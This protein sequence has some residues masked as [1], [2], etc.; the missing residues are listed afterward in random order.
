[1]PLSMVK[2]PSQGSLDGD[3]N[4]P[5]PHG[6]SSTAGGS[7]LGGMGRTLK[8][9]PYLSEMTKGADSDLMAMLS[10]PGG[11]A[12]QA[13]GGRAV[14]AGAP[15][16]GGAAGID[17]LQLKRPGAA[18][19]DVRQAA[20]VMP[21]ATRASATH[22]AGRPLQS[23]LRSNHQLRAAENSQANL[24]S[25]EMRKNTSVTFSQSTK[26]GSRL[27]LVNAQQSVAVTSNKAN[28]TVA[29][30]PVRRDR[31]VSISEEPSSA[32]RQ[33]EQQQGGK[34]QFPFYFDTLKESHVVSPSPSPLTQDFVSEQP[35]SSLQQQESHQDRVKTKAKSVNTLQYYYKAG[36]KSGVSAQNV[37]G[38][39]EKR[40]FSKSLRN[41]TF[42]EMLDE[43]DGKEGDLNLRLRNEQWK[44][45]RTS[46][47]GTGDDDD[48][49]KEDSLMFTPEHRTGS[50]LGS[51]RVLTPSSS[52]NSNDYM[53]DAPNNRSENTEGYS[54]VPMM[55]MHSHAQSTGITQPQ[56]NLI[57]SH[58]GC[59]SAYDLAVFRRAA[60]RMKISPQ[61]PSPSGVH[62]IEPSQSSQQRPGETLGAAMLSRLSSGGSNDLGVAREA[63]P[64]TLSSVMSGK[65]STAGPA[66][67]LPHAS[68]LAQMMANK[69]SVGMAEPP[70]SLPPASKLMS[71]RVHTVSAGLAYGSAGFRMD[72]KTRLS[73]FELGKDTSILSLSSQG[74]G[75]GGFGKNEEWG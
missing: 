7:M 14:T 36:L 58:R 60:S 29:V 21:L 42:R 73:R 37:L 24:N 68:P 32:T 31:S 45:F 47:C 18:V 2:E 43:G 63:A 3:S 51:K 15:T 74:S 65:A 69:L 54:P 66:I 30:A 20:G 48:D 70:A 11:G 57:G 52:T 55:T 61:M 35:S 8:R 1:M 38:S 25:A 56:P 9:S 19:G 10:R 53:G 16:M 5:V 44:V 62:W 64:S 17:F 72:N 4:D 75:Q 39:E 6:D 41:L 67:I 59:V 12:G 40:I 22:L 33:Q 71:R 26:Q 27:G 13:G 50:L 23:A 34:P 28:A 46:D 49:D